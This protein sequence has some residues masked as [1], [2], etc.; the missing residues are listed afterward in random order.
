MGK[1]MK[2]PLSLVLVLIL[3][4]SCATAKPGLEPNAPE[5]LDSF[6][7]NE[8]EPPKKTLTET[9]AG[10]ALEK[11]DIHN[12][13]DEEKIREIYKYLIGSIYFADPIELDIWRYMCEEGEENTPIP[14]IEN[15]SLSPLV[16]GIGS[17]EDFAAVM[18]VLLNAA[19]FEAEYVPGYTISVDGIFIDH[20]W[21]TVKLD[22][23]W[24]H[25]DPQLEQN[26][27][28]E[29]TLRY[30]YYL[31]SDEEMMPDHRWGENLIELW[32]YDITEEEKQLIRERYIPPVCQARITPPEPEYIKLP[33][34]PDMNYI[35]SIAES[36]KYKSGREELLPITLNAEPPVL[37]ATHHITPPL[38]QAL[39]DV[40][41]HGRSFLTQNQ[42]QFYDDI[43]VRL[44]AVEFAEILIPPYIDDDTAYKIIAYLSYDNPGYFWAELTVDAESRSILVKAQNNL[45]R[46]EVLAV[47]A[48][49]EEA[50]EKLLEGI[51]GEDYEIVTAIHDKMVSTIKRDVSSQAAQS[52]NIYGA[53]VN[54]SAICDGY[55]KT[56][57]YL[58]GKMNIP[59]V[60]YTGKG[61]SGTPHAWNAVLMKNEWY[62]ADVTWDTLNPGLILH[63]H[64]GITLEEALRERTFTQGQYPEVINTSWINYNYFIVNSIYVDESGAGDMIDSL[65][66][67][68]VNALE[69]VDITERRRQVFLEVKV[70]G[71]GEAYGKYKRVY[72]QDIFKILD[73]MQ[74]IADERQLGIEITT[75]GTISCNHKDKM[76]I[77]VMFPE[78]YKKR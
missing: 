76:Q 74:R 48:E 38:I 20:A 39:T 67:A 66:A 10:E 41:R 35:N 46:E 12:L 68:F 75:T 40:Y 23:S 61:P 13:S 77:F 27:S 15:R 22:G 17:C 73:K 60:Y 52:G 16:F 63:T 14:F 3:L 5:E 29:D 8:Y 24:Y 72:V 64:L 33:Q 49:A 65:A 6:I 50:A 4:I 31:K 56:F 34:K 54:K 53:L 47:T 71:D 19:G 55:A 51:T 78:V 43:A 30:R 18:V 59:S 21:S 44:E 25:I 58:L 7:E 45:T 1:N 70:L 36:I 69:N 37:S 9:L 62:Y 2:K 32:P 11:L 28:R 26:V 57:Q 42:K